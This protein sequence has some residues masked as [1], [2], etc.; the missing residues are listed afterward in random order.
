MRRNIIL[1]V[2]CNQK[3]TKDFQLDPPIRPNFITWA[4]VDFSEDQ[5][6]RPQLLGL[7]MRVFVEALV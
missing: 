1:N 4:G 7:K 6:G 5:E 3:I 2:I